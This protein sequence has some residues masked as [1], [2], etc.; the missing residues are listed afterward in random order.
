MP[1]VQTHEP[2]EGISQPHK[3]IFHGNPTAR[4]PVPIIALDSQFFF[5]FLLALDIALE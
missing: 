1:G 5:R 4:N 2:K 3:G